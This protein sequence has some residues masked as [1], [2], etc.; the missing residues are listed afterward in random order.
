MVLQL[1]TVGTSW[2]LE[3]NQFMGPTDSMDYG[4]IISILQA[5]HNQLTCPVG[6]GWPLP[7]L[8]TFAILRRPTTQK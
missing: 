5:K 7:L 4:S 6:N 3:S 8:L 2:N 1:A